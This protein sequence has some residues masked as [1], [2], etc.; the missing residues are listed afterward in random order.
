M[1]LELTKREVLTI[2]KLIYSHRNNMPEN[3]SVIHA[4]FVGNLE[5]KILKQVIKQKRHKRKNEIL[6]P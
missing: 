6:L 4:R 2:Q 3:G 5:K 1:I